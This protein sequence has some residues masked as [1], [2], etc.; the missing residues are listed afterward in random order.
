MTETTWRLVV[1]G[2]MT[3]EVRTALTNAGITST[4]MSSGHGAGGVGIE[5]HSF[6]VRAP[7]AEDALTRA[8]TAV[9]GL[10]VVLDENSIREFPIS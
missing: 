7:S 8:Q 5:S 9:T 6:L 2:S 10:P 3:P 4:G 1:R